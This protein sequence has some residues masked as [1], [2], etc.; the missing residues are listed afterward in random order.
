MQ[1]YHSNA[2]CLMSHAEDKGGKCYKSLLGML[3]SVQ[4]AAYHVA[5]NLTLFLLVGNRTWLPAQHQG[6]Q[7]RMKGRSSSMINS[8][9]SAA[10]Q[11]S[12]S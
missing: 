1:G 8:S 6:S 5:S 7:K 12:Y 9:I 3:Y 4:S 10:G 2:G 11:I